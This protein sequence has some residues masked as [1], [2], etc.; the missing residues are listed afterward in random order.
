VN[1]KQD[2]L[3]Q[4]EEETGVDI[5]DKMFEKYLIKFVNVHYKKF[6]NSFEV[7][8]WFIQEILS[9][10]LLTKVSNKKRALTG[11]RLFIKEKNIDSFIKELENY[12]E[13]KEKE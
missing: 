2:I 8:E 6:H 11:L 10:F 12:Y 13:N 3:L 7:G 4:E 9:R 5:I 1:N